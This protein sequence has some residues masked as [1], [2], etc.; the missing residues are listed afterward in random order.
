MQPV[1]AAG[2]RNDGLSRGEAQE[3]ESGE[4]GE[5]A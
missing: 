5:H 2:V 3:G 4:L 1:A